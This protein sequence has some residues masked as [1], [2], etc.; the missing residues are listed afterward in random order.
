M[1]TAKEIKA[2]LAT[3]QTAMAAAEKEVQVQIDAANKLVSD[4][5]LVT[6]TKIKDALKKY[7]PYKQ[8]VEALD[9]LTKAAEKKGSDLTEEEIK[10]ALCKARKF[11]SL[12]VKQDKNNHKFVKSFPNV[13]YDISAILKWLD[14]ETG[15]KYDIALLAIT[16]TYR[17]CKL[18]DVKNPEECFE[19]SAMKD[20]FRSR[21]QD[22]KVKEKITAGAKL[23][24]QSQAEK[25]F[26]DV[27][28][29]FLP[30]VNYK[31][32]KTDG[33]WFLLGATS[34]NKKELGSIKVA[35]YKTIES[36]VYDAIS[37]KLKNNG[38]A[39]YSVTFKTKGKDSEKS[40]PEETAEKSAAPEEKAEP[41]Q[42]K[43]KSEKAAA[44][45]SKEPAAKTGKGGRGK[46]KT[47]AA[48]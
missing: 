10:V 19:T 40:V 28:N 1:K 48:A 29:K 8:L 20:A 17:V 7:R 39:Q 4:N 27:I 30:S 6:D 25:A 43:P 31:A 46:S 3:N 36:M 12:Q 9:L 11:P 22:E 13:D 35:P 14:I 26:Q 24:S 2:A 38:I 34:L 21:M 47:K 37:L 16:L 33:A 44:K 41:K 18:L 15:F 5:K 32:T 45:Q 23:D 42:E